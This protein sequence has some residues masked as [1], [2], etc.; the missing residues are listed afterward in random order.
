[1][2]LSRVPREKCKIFDKNQKWEGNRKT[3]DKEIGFANF[4]ALICT[5]FYDY[6]I[7]HSACFN[8]KFSQRYQK[9]CR[10]WKGIFKYDFVYFAAMGVWLDLTHSFHSRC[11]LR[12]EV[13]SLKS[14]NNALI[15]GRVFWTTHESWNRGYSIFQTSLRRYFTLL[16]NVLKHAL[17][18]EDPEVRQ[19]HRICTELPRFRATNSVSLIWCFLARFHLDHLIFRWTKV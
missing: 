14:L 15:R 19:Q 2:N 9:K 11:W 4:S 12:F 6:P 7:H 10:K 18:L 3:V 5:R 16:L 1:M 17:Y 8:V 13:P